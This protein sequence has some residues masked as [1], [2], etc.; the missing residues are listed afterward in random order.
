MAKTIRVLANGPYEVS[1]DVPL[2]VKTIVPNQNNISTSY[3]EDGRQESGLVPYHLCRCGQ[4]ANKPYCDGSHYAAGFDGTETASRES[5]VNRSEVFEGEA[6]DM[7]QDERCAS[8][9]FCDR[10]PRVWNAVRQSGNPINLQFAKEECANCLA[11]RLTLRGKDGHLM[12]PLLPVEAGLIQ[13]TVAGKRGPIAAIG[14]IDLIDA[15]GQPYEQRN[16][17]TLCRCGQSQ[18]KPFCDTRHLNCPHMAGKDE[19]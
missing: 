14:G 15:D 18:N 2:T 5:Y 3:Q 17:M 7:L 16:R 12:E 13:D 8:L 11:G 9:R 19:L 1:P 4:S 6:V 10:G